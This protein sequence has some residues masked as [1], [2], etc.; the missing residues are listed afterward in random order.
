MTCKSC[1][2]EPENGRPTHWL[3]CKEIPSGGRLMELF[4]EQNHL[5][6]ETCCEH[7]ECTNPKRPQGKGRAPKFCED[8][9]DPKKRK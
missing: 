6:P 3:G 8:H 2:R 4:E 5:S 9:S 1:G 7:G